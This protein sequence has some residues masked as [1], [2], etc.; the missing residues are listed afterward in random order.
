M[1]GGYVVMKTL[2]IEDNA[3]NMELAV[4]LLE[5]A[6]YEVLQATNATDGINLARAERPDLI[7]MDIGLPG[8]NGIEATKILKKDPT[9]IDIPILALTAHNM[10][11]DEAGGL[12]AGCDGYITKPID[13]RQ[14]VKTFEK[15]LLV[16]RPQK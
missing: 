14:F 9:T 8:M 1:L 3:M 2:V 11:G 10:A 7:L 16:E 13:T 12:E 4:D 15:Y 5:V 6:G